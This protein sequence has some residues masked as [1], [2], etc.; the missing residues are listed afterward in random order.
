M[1]SDEGCQP[2]VVHTTFTKVS[3]PATSMK[4]AHN[5]LQPQQRLHTTST[6][7]L[8]SATFPGLVH[9]VEVVHT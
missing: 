4:V 2:P 6:G 9:S 5:I 1:I 3:P 8:P 7:D